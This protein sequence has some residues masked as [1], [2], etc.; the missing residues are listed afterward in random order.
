MQQI[1]SIYS[2]DEIITPTILQAKIK[3]PQHGNTDCG[4]Y[5]IAYATELA[6]GHDPTNFTFDQPQL[7]YHLLNCLTSRTIT[8]F[9]KEEQEI[10]EEPIYKEITVNHKDS[11]KCN[12]PT[13]TSKSTTLKQL[14]DYISHNY[15]QPLNSDSKLTKTTAHNRSRLSNK[16][17]QTKNSSGSKIKNK[18]N[19]VKKPKLNSLVVSLSERTITDTERS[20]LELGLTFCPSQKSFNKEKLSL[21]FFHFIRP[22]KL[23]ER[24]YTNPPVHQ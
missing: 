13:K 24:F 20:V 3:Y 5:P 8:R 2:P 23:R 17:Y 10:N 14:P 9:P 12:I 1:K 18:S 21:D 19:D 22:L 11:K 7:R 15:Y 4:I 16:H 6:F